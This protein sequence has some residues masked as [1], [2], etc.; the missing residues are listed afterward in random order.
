LIRVGEIEAGLLRELQ[1]LGLA[2]VSGGW[3]TMS[4]D[5]AQLYTVTLAGVIGRAVHAAPATDQAI[6]DVASLYFARRQLFGG[7]DAQTPIDGYACA[8]SLAPFPE[9]EAADVPTEKLLKVRQKYASERRAFR[10]LVQA[11][12]VD[13][14]E[15]PSVDAMAS[16]LRDLT[17]ELEAEVDSQRRSRRADYVRDVWKLVGIGT[18]ASIGAVVTL[19]GAPSLVAALGGAGSVAAAVTD[20]LLERRHGH[21]STARYLLSLEWLMGGWRGWERMIEA[22]ERRVRA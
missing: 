9:L 12:A 3:V 7:D 1:A 16:H 5:L 21:R 11:R 4:S 6:C 2:A 22:F 17:T 8:R 15:L 18:P 14:A 20:W 19:A 13:I 10:E